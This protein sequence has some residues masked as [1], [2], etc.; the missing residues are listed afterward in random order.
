MSMGRNSFMIFVGAILSIAFLSTAGRAQ[1][2]TAPM[3][4]SG[5]PS[6]KP[7]IYVHGATGW[8]LLSQASPSK[9]KAKHAYLSSLTYGAVGVPM[10]VEYPGPHAQVQVHTA[11]AICV[12]HILSPNAPMI[13][14]LNEKKKIRELDSGTVHASL[15]GGNGKQGQAETSS[16]VPTS[17]DNSDPGVIVLRPTTSLPAGE[18]AVML[19]A[20]NLAILDFGVI[21]APAK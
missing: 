21:A 7:G 14:R 2:A 20:Q 8:H 13:V 12:S 5:C 15:T 18:Y 9:M 6:G 19:G 1:Q 17:T 3:E 4:G 16:I 10:V 11:Q